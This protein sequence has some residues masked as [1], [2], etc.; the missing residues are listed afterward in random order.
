MRAASA[1]VWDLRNSC[2][3]LHSFESD[4]PREIG[5]NSSNLQLQPGF[6]R[7]A[8]QCE[9]ETPRKKRGMN[10]PE[11]KTH[12]ATASALRHGNLRLLEDSLTGE[13]IWWAI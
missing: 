1:A 11:H 7:C 13:F 2:A 12:P 8:N 10:Q 3:D 5:L 6:G 9:A 4:R